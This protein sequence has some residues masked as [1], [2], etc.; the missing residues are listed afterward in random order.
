[1]TAGHDDVKT[2]VG[3]WTQSGEDRPRKEARVRT[4]ENVEDNSP[5]LTLFLFRQTNAVD[6]IITHCFSLLDDN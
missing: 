3:A 6:S 1:M 5:H 4:R 2:A